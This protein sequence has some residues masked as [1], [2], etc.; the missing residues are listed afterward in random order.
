MANDHHDSST[1]KL[2]Q[3]WLNAMNRQLDGEDQNKES[4]DGQ[5]LSDTG[6]DNKRFPTYLVHHKNGVTV[7]SGGFDDSDSQLS[8][9][10][11]VL[12]VLWSPEGKRLLVND[13]A[14]G[15]LIYKVTGFGRVLFVVCCLLCPNALLRS[16][17]DPHQ[18][19]AMKCFSFRRCCNY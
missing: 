9:D 17:D 13:A 3:L 2:D 10:G 7:A 5:A 12:Q 1:E 6:A 4:Q 16:R 11:E 18:F 8:I 14:K 19:V 15:L